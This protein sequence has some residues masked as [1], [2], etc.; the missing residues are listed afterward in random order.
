[1][2]LSLNKDSTTTGTNQ[3]LGSISV[4]IASARKF[5]TIGVKFLE[6]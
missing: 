3:D 1:M 4:R 2:T 5:L 6:K